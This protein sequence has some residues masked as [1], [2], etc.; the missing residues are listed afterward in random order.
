MGPQPLGCRQ[1][2]LGAAFTATSADPLEAAA[3]HPGLEWELRSSSGL[4]RPPG[5][6]TN[7]RL[8]G[9]DLPQPGSRRCPL[10]CPAGAVR[11]EPETGPWLG[12]GSAGEGPAGVPRVLLGLVVTD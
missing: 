7:P 11:T 8:P 9:P 1:A 5:A 2:A 6:P 10:V 12:H 3:V 4:A